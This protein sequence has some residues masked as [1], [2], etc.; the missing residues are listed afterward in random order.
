M[1][2][3][4][5]LPPVL[6]VREAAAVLRLSVYSVRGLIAD[7]RLQVVRA[8]RAI[9]IPRRCVLA[10]LGEETAPAANGGRDHTMTDRHEPTAT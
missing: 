6:T 8:G 9:R 10:L 5:E 7:G 4:D 2:G 1:S 3:L